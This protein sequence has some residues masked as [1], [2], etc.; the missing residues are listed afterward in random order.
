[1]VDFEF[2]LNLYKKAYDNLNNEIAA[3][4]DLKI[5]SAS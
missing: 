1:M 2:T 5:N 4:Q 3:L